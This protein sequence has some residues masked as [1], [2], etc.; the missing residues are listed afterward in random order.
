MSAGPDVKTAEDETTDNQRIKTSLKK[1][2]RYALLTLLWGAVAAYVIYAG[3][4][5]GRLRAG[6]KVG[7]VE[8]EVVDSSSQGHLVS[9]A[10]V[11][12][13]ISH[14]GIKTLGTAVDAVDLTGIERLI[15][16]NGFVDKTVAYVSYGGTL[17]I[18]ISQR[19]PLVRLLTDGMNAYV[20][21]DGYVFAAPRASSLYVPVVTGS[22]RPPFPASYVGSVREHIDLRLGEIDERIAELE[23]EKYPL[24]RREM[25]N[26]RNISALRRMRIKRQWWRLEGSREFD[27]RVDALREKKAGLRRTYR[28]RAGVIREEIERIAG[29]QEAERRKQK[30]LEKSYEDFMKLL[31]FVETVED[32]D[33]WRSEVV[34]ITAK[35]TPSGAL[36]VELTPRSGRFAVLFGRLEDVERKFDKLLRFYRSGLSSIGWSEYRTIDIRYNDQVVCKK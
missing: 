13:W 33:F 19:K 17:H 35:T 28:Y 10:M 31:T 9:A 32:D 1:Y 8:I 2:L 27:A 6:K 21:A 3:T 11:R 22:Y 30:K 16:R 14:A 36:E 4:A 20:T 23:R 7:R 5:A 34:Q 24:Y 12:Q 18:E 29:L 26:D 25:E 15:A